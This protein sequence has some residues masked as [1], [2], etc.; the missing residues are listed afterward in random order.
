[1]QISI[2]GKVIPQLDDE[3]GRILK[4]IVHVHTYIPSS[5]HIY[6][7]W[8]GPRSAWWLMVSSTIIWVPENTTSTPQARIQAIKSKV[9][10]NG[11]QI[12]LSSF[13]I[14]DP[15]PDKPYSTLFDDFPVIDLCL[16]GAAVAYIQ[17][18]QHRLINQIGKSNVMARLW[19]L[20]YVRTALC[21]IR[22]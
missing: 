4:L 18:K 2:C 1:M 12:M 6:N 7:T 22:H 11:S 17:R 9:F 19:T 8:R 21:W 20:E 16:F 13:T 10:G 3:N 5:P 14:E 15:G